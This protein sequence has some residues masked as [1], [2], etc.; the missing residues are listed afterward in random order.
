MPEKN[1]TIHSSASVLE[2]CLLIAVFL[3]QL[4]L[5]SMDKETTC[6]ILLIIAF[7]SVT[8]LLC[9]LRDAWNALGEMSKE[10]AMTAYV[11]EMKLVIILFVTQAK[12]NMSIH[13]G[14][15]R[16]PTELTQ[17]PIDRFWRACQ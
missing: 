14:M 8:V 5:L 13:F 11:D 4:H 12:L 2:I 6:L 7:F 9:F 17:H 3:L 15:N 1:S 10:E 16:N